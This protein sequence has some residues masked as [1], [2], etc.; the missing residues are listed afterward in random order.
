M[1]DFNQYINA[2]FEPHGRGPAYDC[3]GLVYA[4]YKE[5]LG[6][7][8][9]SYDDRYFSVKD[10]RIADLI[11]A[12]ATKWVRVDKERP[13]DVVVLRIAKYLRHVGTVVKPGDMI[14]ILKECWVVIESYRDLLW[15]NRVV[16]IFR[17]NPR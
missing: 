3:W 17:Y 6:I 9:P 2:P 15:R 8:L 1:I 11:D 5:Q 13:G 7:D 10:K 12:E 4:I 14:H 16:G